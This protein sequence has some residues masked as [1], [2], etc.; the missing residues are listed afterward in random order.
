MMNMWGAQ[1]N[2]S[3]KCG[4]VMNQTMKDLGI[5]FL[6]SNKIGS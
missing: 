1:I 6:F 2:A 4:P 5:N 3:P